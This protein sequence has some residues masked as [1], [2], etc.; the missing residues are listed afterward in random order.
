MGIVGMC[1]I[2]G[3]IIVLIVGDVI[4]VVFIMVKFFKIWI[5]NILLKCIKLFLYMI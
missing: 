5:R 1:V 2:V 3:I 4:I